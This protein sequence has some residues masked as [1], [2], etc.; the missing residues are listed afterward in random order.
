MGSLSE[1]TWVEFEKQKVLCM[2][3]WPGIHCMPPGNL[4]EVAVVSSFVASRSWLAENS[5]W[6][7]E[8]F[9]KRMPWRTH[10]MI[11][12]QNECHS[13]THSNLSFPNQTIIIKKK[14]FKKKS[15]ILY[16][17]ISSTNSSA[18]IS[19]A[20]FCV[21]QQQLPHLSCSFGGFLGA[22][23]CGTCMAIGFP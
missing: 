4:P 16:I 9:N 2:V 22:P 12:L 23:S 10:G 15:Y 20:M 17:I 21:H 3:C 18:T 19:S 14:Y 8:G 13:Y 6:L 1:K 7:C 11:E 5:G